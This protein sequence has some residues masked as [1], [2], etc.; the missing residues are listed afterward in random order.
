[1]TDP[2]K[3]FKEQRRYISTSRYVLANVA[4]VVCCGSADCPIVLLELC[5]LL[6]LVEMGGLVFLVEVGG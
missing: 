4:L 6:S 5:V 3:Y 2:A 1:M